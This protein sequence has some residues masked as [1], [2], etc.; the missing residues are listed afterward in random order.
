MLLAANVLRGV[1]VTT[2]D[3]AANDCL[4]EMFGER[5]PVLEYNGSTISWP[6]SAEDAAALLVDRKSS[7]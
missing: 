2:I 7:S 6:F 4:F 3:V 1:I 5:I